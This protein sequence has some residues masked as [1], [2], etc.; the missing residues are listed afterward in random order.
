MGRGLSTLQLKILEALEQLPPEEARPK[1]IITMLDRD[2]TSS[3][4]VAVSKALRRLIER[5][6][7]E[8]ASTLSDTEF[9]EVIREAE[10]R[11]EVKAFALRRTQDVLAGMETPV[12]RSRRYS[13]AARQIIAR[14]EAADW[15]RKSNSP[16]PPQSLLS[17]LNSAIPRA[18][19]TAERREIRMTILAELRK[20]NPASKGTTIYKMATPYQRYQSAKTP[21]EQREAFKE[22]AA[23]YRKKHGRVDDDS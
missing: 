18:K 9:L 5:G 13:T 20:G 23:L 10:Q 8:K 14:V 19:T 15:Y 2:P 11:A 3:N 16:P 21:A 17:R 6:L 1:D 4:R 12:E 7:V 22:M